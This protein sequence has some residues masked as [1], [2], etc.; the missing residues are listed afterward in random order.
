MAA[1]ER[2]D[3]ERLRY[4][5][6]QMLR[7]RD[8]R[9]Q[10]AQQAQLRWWHNRALHNAFGVVAGLGV[11]LSAS[12]GEP[13]VTVAPGLAYDGFGRE[14]VLRREESIAVPVDPEPLTLLLEDAA[15]AAGSRVDLAWKTSRTVG[16]GDG[17]PLA[18]LRLDEGRPVLDRSS[19]PIMR[20]LARPRIASGATIPGQT[21]WQVWDALRDQ[22]ASPLAPR[23]TAV[24]TQP[25]VLAF[26]VRIDTAAAGFTDAPLYFARLE[27]RLPRPGSPPAVR[28]ASW[29]HVDD[30]SIAGFTFRFFMIVARDDAKSAGGRAPILLGA[31]LLEFLRT[32]GVFVSWHGIEPGPARAAA[33]PNT[34]R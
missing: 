18:R 16:I 2:R 13:T 25:P 19:V 11:T 29:A 23:A 14:L 32:E 7:S 26:Q 20:R 1:S 24:V 8:F 4:W 6:G 5:Q 31:E 3:L 21:P 28:A 15:G 22:I 34:A 9:D 17:V 10:A 33:H 27:G 30:A 12:S